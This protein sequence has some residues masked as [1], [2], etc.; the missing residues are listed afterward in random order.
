MKDKEVNKLIKA[1]NIAAQKQVEHLLLIKNADGTVK[2]TGTGNIL[3]AVVGNNDLFTQVKNAVLSSQGPNVPVHILCY[4][5][6]PCSPFS[7][8]W[9]KKGSTVRI[10]RVLQDMIT[11]AGFG[12]YGKKLGSNDPPI[13]WPQDIP[14]DTFTGVGSSGLKNEDM[15]RII[16]EMLRA[17]D[18]D[19]ATHVQQNQEEEH[20]EEEEQIEEEHRE[21]HEDVEQP[22]EIRDPEFGGVADPVVLNIEG[23]D[24]MFDQD[25]D[26]INLLNI[27]QVGHEELIGVDDGLAEHHQAPVADVLV[28]QPQALPIGEGGHLQSVIGDEE[29]HGEQHYVEVTSED[30][31]VQKPEAA[32]EDTH[33]QQYEGTADII[34][35]KC[36]NIQALI[37]GDET[38]PIGQT[39]STEVGSGTIGQF[40]ENMNRTNKKRRIGIN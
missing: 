30:G 9:N 22:P 13:G 4:P 3:G 38:K 10:R 35:N 18:I 27:N 39:I 31:P 36:P 37:A 14:W 12:K 20:L 32:S 17:A 7:P 25:V 34:P 15:T 33:V 8:E 21:E 19:P 26:L 23:A 29:D 1:S 2:C 24:I 40:D 28:Q 11:E 16:L 5:H 6:L